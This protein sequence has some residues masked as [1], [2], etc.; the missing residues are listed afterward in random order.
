MS[1]SKAGDSE[2]SEFSTLSKVVLK[3]AHTLPLP[4]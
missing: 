3:I 1:L 2:T 4:S